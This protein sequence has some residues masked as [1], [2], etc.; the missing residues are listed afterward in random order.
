MPKFERHGFC[1]LRFQKQLY[2]NKA[3]FKIP[4]S[5]GKFLKRHGPCA[6]LVQ[7]LENLTVASE[8]MEGEGGKKTQNET[9]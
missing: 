1:A 3:E 2:D 4:Q 8:G 6:L 9:W 5:R 7:L